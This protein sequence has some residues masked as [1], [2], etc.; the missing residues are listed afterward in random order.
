MILR[1]RIRSHSILPLRNLTRKL[2]LL[3]QLSVS[4]LKRTAE[5]HSLY[6]VAKVIFFLYD[7]D[8]AELDLKEEFGASSYCL[9]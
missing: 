1:I 3:D 8:V 4:F 5:V 9:S 2:H 7:R 6:C